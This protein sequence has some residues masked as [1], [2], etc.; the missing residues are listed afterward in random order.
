MRAEIVGQRRSHGHE[1]NTNR[2][3]PENYNESI[4]YNM[5]L[6]Q[7]SEN[8]TAGKDEQILLLLRGV[9]STRGLLAYEAAAGSS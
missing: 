6:F 9:I 1:R 4:I 5:A 3:E 7:V 2:R 8:L